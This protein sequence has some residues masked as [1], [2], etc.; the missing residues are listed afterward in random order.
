MNKLDLYKAQLLWW[1][2]CMFKLQKPKSPLQ[3]VAT[4][5]TYKFGIT[6]YKFVNGTFKLRK[7]L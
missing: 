6:N 5:E 1:W 3:Q 4:I 2:K 7:K